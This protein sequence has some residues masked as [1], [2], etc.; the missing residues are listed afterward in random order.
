M[1]RESL[2]ARQE[3]RED[4]MEVDDDGEP[5]AF[6]PAALGLHRVG[7]KLP[8]KPA[9]TQPIQVLNARGMPAR[10]RKKNRLFYDDNIINDK[11]PPKQSPRKLGK[12]SPIKVLQ[13]PSRI[14]KRGRMKLKFP[15]KQSP[16]SGKVLGRMRGQMGR[17]VTTPSPTQPLDKKLGQRVGMRLRN[18]LKLPKAHKFVSYEWF[19]STIDKPLFEGPND[20]EICLKEAFPQLITRSMS[21]VEWTRIRRMMGKPRRC[22]QAFFDEERREL[23]RKRQKLRLLQTRKLGDVSFVKDLPSSVPLTLPVGTTVTARLRKPQDGLFTGVVAA[24]DSHHHTYRITF[25][26]QGLGTQTIPDY[27]LISNSTQD[28]I[29]LSSLT[30]NFRQK[31]N[32]PKNFVA[33]PL[34]CLTTLGKHDPMLSVDVFSHLKKPQ[35]L[36]YPTDKQVGGYPVKLL[37]LMVRTKKLLAAKQVKLNRLQSLNSEVAIHKSYDEP[38]TEETQ[39]IYANLVVSL[40]KIN[41]NVQANLN[42]IQTFTPQI[43][44]QP[45]ILS[46]LTPSYLREKC[47]EMGNQT[48]QTNNHGGMVR[49]PEVVR[50]ISDMATIMWV[51]SSLSNTEQYTNVLRV[52]EGCLEETKNRLSPENVDVFHKCVMVHIHQIKMGLGQLVG[53]SSSSAQSTPAAPTRIVKREPEEGSSR[54]PMVKIFIESK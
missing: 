50:L 28:T 32:L 53:P 5:P 25:E 27:E 26:R 16:S 1:P 7:T 37:E 12:R 20:F 3:V 39:K 43:S 23:E 14:M 24:V 31:A 48:V 10:I 19:Y 11:P 8:P 17:P 9:P 18:L 52:L 4:D 30:K 45:Q 22:S 49:D 29:P 33:S 35:S 51:A 21:R 13:T 42:Q 2:K 15:G 41:R 54:A 38:I 44:K 6:G 47:R 40:E 34:N 36:K 46:M